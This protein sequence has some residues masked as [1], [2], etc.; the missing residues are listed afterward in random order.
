[1]TKLVINGG[2]PTVSKGLKIKWPIFNSADKEALM[3]VLES[4]K[5]CSAGWYFEKPLESKVAQFE[6]EF[7]KWCGT[8]YGIATTDGTSALV[9]A[10]K[11]GGVEAD[12][13]VIIPAVTFIKKY[14]YFM[15]YISYRDMHAKVRGLNSLGNRE[16]V[17]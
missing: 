14:Q 2:K 11:A 16:D 8:K 15:V 7:A 9:L 6:K 17:L 1:M 13:E 4:G 12:D 5:W 3:E 10:L